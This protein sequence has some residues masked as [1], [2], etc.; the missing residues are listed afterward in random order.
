MALHLASYA[1]GSWLS[2][3]LP[4]ALS[5][6]LLASKSQPP[7]AGTSLLPVGAACKRPAALSDCPKVVATMASP[8]KRRE[9]D[10]MKL[11]VAPALRTA[12]D[13]RR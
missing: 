4:P 13:L 7:F 5:V 10:L 8:G 12:S 3:A 11:Y 9:M 6:S 1:A 2:I